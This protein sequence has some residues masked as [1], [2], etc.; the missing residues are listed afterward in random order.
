MHIYNALS[1]QADFLV[2]EKQFFRQYRFP[3]AEIQAPSGTS[4]LLLIVN[5]I[6]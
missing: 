4:G 5:I 6:T 3:K 1:L 2:K